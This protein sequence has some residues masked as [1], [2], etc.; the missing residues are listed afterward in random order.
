M[1]AQKYSLQLIQDILSLQSITMGANQ[2]STKNDWVC[3][4]MHIHQHQ[5][6]KPEIHK[7]VIRTP[8]TQFSATGLAHGDCLIK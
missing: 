5:C 6:T 7:H 8:Q 1:S 2:T 4:R 3:C